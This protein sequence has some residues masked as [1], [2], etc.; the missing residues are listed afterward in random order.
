MAVDEAL[1]R[2]PCGPTGT[3]SQYG[4]HIALRRRSRRLPR[5]KEVAKVDPALPIEPQGPIHPLS[6]RF[7]GGQLLRRTTLEWNCVDSS[8]LAIYSRKM[9]ADWDRRARENARHNIASGREDWSDEEFFRSGRQTVETD[10]LND[11]DNICQGKDPKRMTILEIGCGEGRMTRPLSEIFGEVHGVDVSGEMI[12][13]AHRTLTD[14]TNVRLY[15]NNGVDLSVLPPVQFDFAY[16]FVVFQ[17]IPTREIVESYVRE[18]HRVLLP[19]ALFKF[20][21]QGCRTV[22]RSQDDTWLGVP[23]GD[24]EAVQ[25]ALRCGFDPRYRHGAGEQ[26]FYLWFYK[27]G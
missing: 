3:S 21:V 23:I 22:D 1:R 5:G 18:V 12:A 26:Y 25:M 6:S 2:E 8:S 16:S 20:Q 17:H 19:G 4:Y 14:L 13:R 9:E 11:M 27:R 7:T 15:K 24:Q 10:I